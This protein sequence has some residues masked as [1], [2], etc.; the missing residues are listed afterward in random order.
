MTT[1]D[2]LRLRDRLAP[3]T[4]G[5]ALADRLAPVVVLTPDFP[6]KSN[7]QTAHLR[8]E[9]GLVATTGGYSNDGDT[10]D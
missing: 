3:L 6:K 4:T 2:P 8:G 10:D 1:Y 9:R 5:R 7:D